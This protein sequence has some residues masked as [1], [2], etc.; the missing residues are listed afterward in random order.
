MLEEPRRAAVLP[1]CAET[2]A[3]N[4]SAIGR[5]P[6]LPLST[7]AVIQLCT[8]NRLWSALYLP[9]RQPASHG[10]RRRSQYRRTSEPHASRAPRDT[11]SQTNNWLACSGFLTAGG[12]AIRGGQ[13]SRRRR[14]PQTLWSKSPIRRVGIVCD[15]V[16][17]ISRDVEK[18]VMG[19][20]WS[21]IATGSRFRSQSTWPIRRYAYRHLSAALPY[22]R[23]GNRL[24]RQGDKISVFPSYW[25][26][27]ARNWIIASGLRDGHIKR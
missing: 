5:I 27:Q 12:A 6:E 13:S 15:R 26:A 20:G 19:Y 4:S 21:R 16:E 24:Q 22:L 8:E 14:K 1:R 23:R 17:S 10:A 9:R 2:R 7:N 11:S 3:K 18:Q 25:L